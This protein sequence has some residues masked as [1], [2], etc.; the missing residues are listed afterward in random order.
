MATVN[1]SVPDDVSRRSTAIALLR[2]DQ[3]GETIFC[4]P[5]HFVAEVAAVLARKNR[6][7]TPERT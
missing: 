2:T 1:F 4:Q 5:P 3:N 7:I 6:P